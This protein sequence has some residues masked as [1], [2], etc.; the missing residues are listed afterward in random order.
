MDD[1][2]DHLLKVNQGRV[3]YLNSLITY[4]EIEA[5][6]QRHPPPNKNSPGADS[7]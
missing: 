7:F 3:T 2:L 6:I 4:K 5:V 1:L